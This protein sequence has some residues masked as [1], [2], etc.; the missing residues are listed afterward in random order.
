MATS[1]VA[2]GPV[3]QAGA[4]LE[5]AFG[6]GEGSGG[7]GVFAAGVVELGVG[8]GENDDGIDVELVELGAGGVAVGDQA[9][10]GA[11]VA[12]EFAEGGAKGL[13]TFGIPFGAVDVDGASGAFDVDQVDGVGGEEG[14]IDFKV[15]AVA[16]DLEVVDE[17]VGV[18][19]AIAQV[20][21]DE[22]F[23]IVDGLANRNHLCHQAASS[24]AF[25]TRA[26]ASFSASMARS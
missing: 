20:G 22:A 4:V 10:E 6:A 1:D 12:F 3:G 5:E 8:G 18:G 24:I 17:G 9:F 15:L 21:D 11:G 23:G 13:A 19:E 14:D 26:I 7:F 2:V 25:S 16:G